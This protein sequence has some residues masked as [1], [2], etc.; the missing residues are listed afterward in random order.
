MQYILLLCVTLLSPLSTCVILKERFLV[1]TACLNVSVTNTVRYYVSILLYYLIY[2][3]LLVNSS[4]FCFITMREVVRNRRFGT[5]YMS[6]R[7]GRRCPRR[8][9]IFSIEGKTDSPETSVY[10]QLTPRNNLTG[11]RIQFNSGGSIRSRVVLCSEP[12]ISFI[13]M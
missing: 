9:N 12:K 1:S 11:G 13:V 7:Q 5:T 8:E 4:V 10:N 3:L 6:H 2:Q